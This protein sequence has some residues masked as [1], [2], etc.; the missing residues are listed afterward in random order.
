MMYSQ[1]HVDLLN[2]QLD[3]KRKII[4]GLQKDVLKWEARVKELEAE[5]KRLR[6]DINDFAR[7]Q[8]CDIPDNEGGAE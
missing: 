7:D 4:L 1:E 8:G 5:N 3:D 6:E 2:K